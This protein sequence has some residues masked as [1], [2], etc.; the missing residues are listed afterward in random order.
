MISVDVFVP[1]LD[2]SY[3]FSLSEDAPVG[4]IVEEIVEMICQKEHWKEAENT[5]N[6]ILSS[7]QLRCVLHSNTTLAR[8]D[9]T[10]G[11]RLILT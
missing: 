3:D 11:A 9:V 5:Q 10:T 2:K 7:P 1:V 4:A 8:A 6:L